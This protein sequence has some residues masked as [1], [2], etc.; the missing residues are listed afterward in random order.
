MYGYGWRVF[1]GYGWWVYI[2]DRILL[3]INCVYILCFESIFEFF[4][5]VLGSDMIFFI[6]WGILGWLGEVD[7]WGW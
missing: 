7:F 1:L 5:C 6:Y 3:G 4:I 2:Y